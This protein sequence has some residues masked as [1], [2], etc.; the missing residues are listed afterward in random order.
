VRRALRPHRPAARH[1]STGDEGQS[2]AADGSAVTGSLDLGSVGETGA[3]SS[4]GGGDGDGGEVVLPEV[5]AI[6]LPE[7]VNAAGPVPITVQAKAASVRVKLD[8]VD[9]GELV[10]RRRRR[11]SWASSRSRAPSSN[12]TRQVEVLATLGEHEASGEATFE[13][14]VPEAGK[15]AWAK[16]GPLGSRTNRIALTPEGDVIEAGLR[17]G[18]DIPRPSVHKRSGLNGTDLWGKKVLLS[19]L[20]GHVA[21]VAIAPDGGIWV[22]MNV[23]EVDQKW[24]PHI[25]LLA[26]D[27]SPTGVDEP[28]AL[29]STLRAIAA[30]EEG[31][32]FGVG[33]AVVEG[34]DLDVVY[35]GVNAAHQ[36]T[37]TDPWDYQPPKAPAHSFAD[38]AMDVVIDGDV[39]WVAGLSVGPARW[40]GNSYTRGMIVPIDIHTG[41]VVGPVIIAPASELWKHSVFFGLALDCGRGSGHGRGLS[42][43][44]RRRAAHRDL[45]L[46]ARRRA[47]L[48]S[49]RGPGRGCVWE[50]CR[51]RLAGSGH[52]RGGEQAGR[53]ASWPGLCPDDRQ[54]RAVRPCGRTGSRSARSPRRPWGPRAM[55]TTESSSAA[56]SPPA[57]RRRRGS[58][59][60]A[61]DHCGAEAG[62]G[63]TDQLG[64]S[65]EVG[66]VGGRAGVTLDMIGEHGDQLAEPLL[67]LVVVVVGAAG[68]RVG[69]VLRCHEQ[70]DDGSRVAVLGLHD[71]LVPVGRRRSSTPRPRCR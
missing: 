59:R 52:R 50:R 3:A 45:A 1:A 13:V 38:A 54:G 8:G 2:G 11:C 12:G 4:T 51:G 20:E 26:P 42:G 23:K 19:E 43:W 15:P 21:D 70:S 44:L 61:R 29:G 37:V 57:A 71:R 66:R 34:G 16:P 49:A 55:S 62:A 53:C 7:E 24:R 56:T 17:I 64:R 25:L 27:G 46:H 5:L 68:R 65:G 35:Q 9:V 60:S 41:A 47:H 69:H 40:Q 63:F 14:K 32:C 30:D 48:A 10:G 58:C 31:G 36:G 6:E 22:A 67:V 18:A 28:G 33:F 39:A